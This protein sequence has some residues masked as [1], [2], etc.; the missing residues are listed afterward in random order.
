MKKLVNWNKMSI[1]AF[2]AVMVVLSLAFGLAGCAANTISSSGNTSS[3]AESG[4][5]TLQIFAVYTLANAMNEAQNAYIA[6]GHSNITFAET[7]Y[8]DSLEL[9]DMLAEGSYAD[10]FIAANSGILASAMAGG[11][12]DSATEVNILKDNIVMVAKEDSDISQV[13]LDD[14]ASRKYSISVGGNEVPEG[15]YA[16]QALSTVKVFYP[17]SQSELGKTGKE[18]SGRDGRFAGVKKTSIGDT[19]EEVCKCVQSGEIDIAFIYSSD[20]Y[21]FSGLKVVGTVPESTHKDI[22]YPAALTKDCKNVEETNEFLD[23]CRTSP[24]A[25]SIWEKW[26]LKSATS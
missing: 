18:I 15:P 26:G 24:K 23:W 16:A 25:E 10:A 22:F 19:I 21:R 6:D 9:V 20:V 17:V 5:T 7:Q 1:S 4:T 14:I 8:K 11:D 13:T 2:M 3:E 12:V